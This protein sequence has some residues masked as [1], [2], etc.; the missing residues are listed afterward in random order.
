MKIFTFIIFPFLILFATR[1]NAELKLTIKGIVVNDKKAAI[2]SV[3]IS[4][5]NAK[6]STLLIQV[7]SKENGKYEIVYS[8]P[9]DFILKYESIGFKTNFST[10]FM[11][12]GG[13]TYEALPAQLETNSYNLNNVTVTSSRKVIQVNADKMIFNVQNSINSTGSN[14]LELLQKSPGIQVDDNDHISYKGKAGL[15]IYIDGKMTHLSNDDL[16]A[17]LKSINSNDID[18]IEII[19][20]P[21][22]QYDASGNAG[23]I[24]IKLK[25]NKNFGTNGNF[26]LGLTHAKTPKGNDAVS[27]NY[28][29]KKINIFSNAGVNYGRNEV[30][31]KAF[32]VQKDTALKIEK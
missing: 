26:T 22:A 6:D 25:K 19:N 31:I 27:Q 5:L 17:Y 21:G 13:Q 32:R 11:V 3:N 8:L 23:V 2:P 29:N 16:A 30:D 14:A 7:T 9:G 4:L 18:A 15:Q 28:R 1:A 24:N 10:S 12:K 20:N